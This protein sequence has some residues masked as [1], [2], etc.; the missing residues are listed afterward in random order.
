M[1]GRK[2]NVVRGAQVEVQISE[3]VAGSGPAE[4]IK[5]Q[6][7]RVLS[8]AELERAL[9]EAERSGLRFAYIDL[10]VYEPGIVE[11]VLSRSNAIPIS[12]VG[13]SPSGWHSRPELSAPVRPPVAETEPIARW[14]LIARGDKPECDTQ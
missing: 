5:Y 3:A 6:A 13:R 7:I 11:Q 12:G 4:H 2:V 10:F 9:L 8:V 14:P 1:K